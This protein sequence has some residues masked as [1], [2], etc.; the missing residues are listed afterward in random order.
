[1]A[2]FL[3]Y[4]VLLKKYKVQLV[5][6]L[7]R[8]LYLPPFLLQGL[9]PLNTAHPQSTVNPGAVERGVHAQGVQLHTPEI[10]WAYKTPFCTLCLN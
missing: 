2:N 7:E 4:I 5:K 9:M 1:M 10:L 8:C 6:I 3:C